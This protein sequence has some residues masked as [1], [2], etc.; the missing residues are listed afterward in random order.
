MNQNRWSEYGHSLGGRALEWHS[1]GQRF[2]PAY[3]HQ[4]KT[5]KPYWFQ[6]FLFCPHGRGGL[7][8]AFAACS[9]EF[10]HLPSAAGDAEAQLNRRQRQAKGR[11][12]HAGKKENLETNT[13]SRFFVGGDKRDRTADLLNAI[14][15]LSQLSYTPIFAPAILVHRCRLAQ[16]STAALICQH[17]FSKFFGFFPDGEA[18]ASPSD[19]GL[20]RF[21]AVRPGAQLLHRLVR[22]GGRQPGHHADGGGGDDVIFCYS[23]AFHPALRK[24]A[25]MAAHICRGFRFFLQAYC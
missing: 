13:V 14:Q 19:N 22:A 24:E 2:D 8:P 10:L 15:A 9:A 4:R 6:G 18:A 25:C 17:F 16:Y 3:L 5:L 1:R 7:W 23:R 11:R 12:A 20:G 21:S